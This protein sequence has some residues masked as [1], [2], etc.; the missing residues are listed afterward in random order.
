[1][2]SISARSFYQSSR[3]ATLPPLD[4]SPDLKVARSRS[5]ESLPG[6]HDSDPIA[7]FDGL[8][9]ARNTKSTRSDL[10]LT[11]TP[12]LPPP[13]CPDFASALA[14]KLVLCTADCFWD[15]ADADL[16]AKRIKTVALTEILDLVRADCRLANPQLAQLIAAIEL[17][18][19]RRIPEIQPWMLRSDDMILITEPAW[20][21]YWLDYQI[22]NAIAAAFPEYPHFSEA[23]YLQSL[24]D[25]FCCSDLNE[26]T[27]VANLLIAIQTARPPLRQKE[28][29]LT[30]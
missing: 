12:P 29:P 2:N 20:P 24:F 18:I 10:V 27:A 8:P 16:S 4:G 19:F 6:V 26:R 3:I 9:R 21:H 22:M 25:K 13:D 7:D 5:S 23:S 1:M 30:L 11:P 17:S 14:A 15:D 28:R